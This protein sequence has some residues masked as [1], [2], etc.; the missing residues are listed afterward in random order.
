MVGPLRG[1]Y[2]HPLSLNSEGL[3]LGGDDG[4][5]TGFVLGGDDGLVPGFVL[6]GDDS[7]GGRRGLI[8]GYTVEMGISFGCFCS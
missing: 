7:K 6:G 2:P 3:V 8:L 5:D 4:L 1:S